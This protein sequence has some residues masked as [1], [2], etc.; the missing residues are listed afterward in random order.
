M[1][2][3]LTC[4][5]ATLAHETSLILERFMEI[6]KYDSK[7]TIQG[8]IHMGDEIS[9]VTIPNILSSFEIKSVYYAAAT[10]GLFTV[11]LI[12]Y[13][14]SFLMGLMCYNN[15]EAPGCSRASGYTGLMM[16]ISVAMSFP[17]SSALMFVTSSVMILATTVTITSRT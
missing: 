2:N 15:P 9:E 6:L 12:M 4:E 8:I 7:M 13:G 11:L 1:Y 14:T 17:I 5:A 10:T 3:T 16:I